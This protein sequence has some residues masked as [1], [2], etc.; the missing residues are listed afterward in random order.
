[1]SSRATRALLKLY[2]RR[3][4]DRYGDE[5]LD[6][7]DELRAHGD[8]SRARLIR[9]MLTGALLIRTNHQRARLAI[10]AVLVVGGLAVA[11]AMLG[12]RGT[13]SLA[14]PSHPRVQLEAQTVMPAPYGACPVAAGSSCS[15]TP[16]AE[17]IDRS[18]DNGVT[19]QPNVPTIR[20]RPPHL[21]TASR[22]PAQ[23]HKGPQSGALVAQPAMPT[24]TG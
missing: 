11:G 17:F 8:V 14:R 16:C 2:P 3:I 12:E 15:V 7:E 18:A 20:R 4:R 21:I 10:G 24:S 5:L 23:R 6:L 22:C 9:D 13:D 19:A 1:M